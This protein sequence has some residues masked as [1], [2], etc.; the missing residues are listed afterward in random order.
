VKEKFRQINLNN[1]LFPVLAVVLALFLSAVLISALGFD[2]IFAYRNLLEGSLGNLRTIGETI[3]RTTPLIFTGLSFAIGKRCGLINLGAEGQVHMGGL[4]ATIVGVNF[5]GLPMFIH[6]PFAIIAGMLGGG[7]L[8]LLIGWLKNRFG[9]SEL[10][11]GIMFNY[12][13]IWLVSYFVTTGPLREGDFPQSARMFETARL[14]RIIEGTRIH[15][16]IFLALLAVLFFYMFLWKTTKGYELR[17]VGLNPDAAKYSGINVRRNALL[18]M[19]M[20]GG[21]AGLAGCVEI[22]GVQL[23]LMQGFSPDYGF[24]G[25]AVSLLGNNSPIGILLAALLFGILK[26]GSN[27]MQASAHVPVAV[28]QIIQALVI[29]FVVG[30]ELYPR[31]SR[32]IKK[33][34]SFYQKK[35]GELNGTA[36]GN[37]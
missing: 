34:K 2:W 4:F 14:P 26:S 36:T 32:F 1:I 29:L 7:F 33:S 3:I 28:V 31:L 25:I 21:F 30:R 6:L 20:A 23:R 11:T 15:A 17:T 22:L 12:I 37:H 5:S 16:G 19:F 10:I 24:D 13:A 9:A 35:G 27:Q 18:A 8:G